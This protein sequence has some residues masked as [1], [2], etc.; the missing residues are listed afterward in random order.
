MTNLPAVAK[1]VMPR[2]R[3]SW[4]N[5]FFNAAR[6]IKKKANIG[7]T[8]AAII[9]VGMCVKTKRELVTAKPKTSDQRRRSHTLERNRKQKGKIAQAAN[10][11]Y[12]TYWK[13][14]FRRPGTI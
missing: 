2:A 3:L 14:S 6:S 7:N 11:A 10:S 5:V 1:S 9:V 12:R 13:I 8:R 4:S